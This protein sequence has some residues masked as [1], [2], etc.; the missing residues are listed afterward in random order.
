[1][2]RRARSD[3]NLD[4]KLL[5]ARDPGRKAIRTTLECIFLLFSTLP[6]MAE[7]CL[8]RGTEAR[9]ESLPVEKRQ[10]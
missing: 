1:V 3:D 9:R 6:A 2:P 8:K 5:R 7:W 10:K 4:N